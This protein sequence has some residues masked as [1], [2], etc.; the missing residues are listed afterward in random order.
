MNMDV[1]LASS[2]GRRRRPRNGN[3]SSEEVE[4]SALPV[5]TRPVVETRARTIVMSVVGT[6]SQDTVSCCTAPY[7]CVSAGCNHRGYEP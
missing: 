3:L 6:P 7:T 2:K 1:P 4:N 5:Q